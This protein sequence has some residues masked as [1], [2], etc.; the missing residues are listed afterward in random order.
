M[1]V[2]ADFCQQKFL[3]FNENQNFAGSTIKKA[4]RLDTNAFGMIFSQHLQLLLSSRT[5]IYHGQ[6]QNAYTSSMAP[7]NC[8][9]VL[10]GNIKIVILKSHCLCRKSPIARC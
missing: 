3:K 1:G 9:A 10:E 5:C 7:V 8:N 4:A 2:E 6:N